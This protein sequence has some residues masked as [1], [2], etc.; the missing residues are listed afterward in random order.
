MCLAFSAIVCLGD[1]FAYGQDGAAGAS[2]AMMRF[3]VRGFSAQQ[4]RLPQSR[5]KSGLGVREMFA[6][7]SLRIVESDTDL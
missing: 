5:S 7:L 3:N 1:Q 6:S 4:R 2:V